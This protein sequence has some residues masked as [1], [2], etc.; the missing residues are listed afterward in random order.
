MTVK[1]IAAATPSPGIITDPEA[2]GTNTLLV[3]GIQLPGR[4]IV[5][6][7]GEPRALI[8]VGGMGLDGQT[9]R[10]GGNRSA[11]FKITVVMWLPAIHL[12]LYARVA[13]LFQRP[14]NGKPAPVL[15]LVHPLLANAGITKAMVEDHHGPAIDLTTWKGCFVA[16]VDFQEWRTPVPRNPKPKDDIPDANVPESPQD[17]LRSEFKRKAAEVKRKANL[18]AQGKP[19]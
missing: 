9:T 13:P 10:F 16:T 14:P 19:E 1:A 11:K 8:N 12:P 2:Y 6:T 17:I 18:A 3:N 4:V 7:P 15:D 5:D